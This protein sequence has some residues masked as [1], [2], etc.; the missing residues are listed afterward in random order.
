MHGLN[1]LCE[2]CK[3]YWRWKDE[4]EI[5][6]TVATKR[7]K[8]IF[9]TFEGKKVEKSGPSSYIWPD[10]LFPKKIGGLKDHFEFSFLFCPV[11]KNPILKFSLK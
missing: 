10:V 4:G 7:A 8:A 1:T 3:G 6:R 9:G 5:V 2:R 11:L